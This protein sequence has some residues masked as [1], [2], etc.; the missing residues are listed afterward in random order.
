MAREQDDLQAQ[1]AARRAEA[2][3]RRSRSRVRESASTSSAR[4]L[5]TQQESRTGGM[6]RDTEAGFMIEEDDDDDVPRRERS[7]I[8][9]APPIDPTQMPSYPNHPHCKECGSEF[10][11]STLQRNFGLDV[12]NACRDAFKDSAY[13]LITKTEAM[14]EYLLK[15]RDLDPS[16]PDSLRHIEKKNPHR[17]HWGKMK[18]FLRCQ[19]EEK[20][21]QRYGGEAGLDAEIARKAE[22]RRK[23]KQRLSAKKMR[24]LRVDTFTSTW[25]EQEAEHMHKFQEQEKGD[26]LWTK[27][28]TEC[29]FS[30]DFEKM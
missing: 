26:G 11:D 23:Q 19:V 28:C 4:Q 6:L 21:Y 13:G 18:L 29:G 24:K 27:T 25:R 10:F 3:A 22:D 14:Q 16:M 7:P 2:V 20:S 30:V 15:E 8:R 5:Q 17:E 12:C 1:I 9:R